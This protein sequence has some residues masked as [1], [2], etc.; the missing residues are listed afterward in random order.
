MET[1]E[2]IEAGLQASKILRE[3]FDKDSPLGGIGNIVDDLVKEA[4]MLKSELDSINA[5]NKF[6]AMRRNSV[7]DTSWIWV[8]RIGSEVI[9]DHPV[10]PLN[11]SESFIVEEIEFRNDNFYARGENTMWFNVTML[12]PAKEIPLEAKNYHTEYLEEHHYLTESAIGKV[13]MIFMDMCN[14]IEKADRRRDEAR[15]IKKREEN[16]G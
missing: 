6:K 10:T 13:Q 1:K 16:G 8:P 11:P 7:S 14:S 2:I 9:A 3:S 12:R 15:L 5:F 4:R